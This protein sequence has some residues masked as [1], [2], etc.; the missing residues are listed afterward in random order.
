MLTNYLR[1]PFCFPDRFIRPSFYSAGE[2][3]RNPFVLQR[4]MELAQL[5]VTSAN[6]EDM[7]GL[8]SRAS[9]RDHGYGVTG[10]HDGIGKGKKPQVWV[11]FNS[12][13][14]K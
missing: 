1:D 9:L 7:N 12:V 5:F 6:A 13:P 2:W 8:T 14:K 11:V 4:P 10:H 3:A